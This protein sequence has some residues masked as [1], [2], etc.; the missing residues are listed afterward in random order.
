MSVRKPGGEKEA[1]GTGWSLR[2]MVGVEETFT[3]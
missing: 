2:K 3:E 1:G